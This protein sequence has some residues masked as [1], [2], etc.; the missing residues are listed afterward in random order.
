MSEANAGLTERRIDLLNA[1]LAARRTG[2]RVKDR[3]RLTPVE[4]KDH[5]QHPRRNAHVRRHEKRSAGRT[6]SHDE[7][8]VATNLPSS[9]VAAEWAVQNTSSPT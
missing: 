1:R 3:I 6:P 9:T 4:A 5:A 8:G 2:A 7:N